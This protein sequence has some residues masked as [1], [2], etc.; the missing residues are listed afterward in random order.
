MDLP[1]YT[2]LTA[3][4]AAGMTEAAEHITPSDRTRPPILLSDPWFWVF[5]SRIRAGQIES[6]QENSSFSINSER[7]KP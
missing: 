4:R 7:E 1:S 2:C 6:S 3:V 5:L